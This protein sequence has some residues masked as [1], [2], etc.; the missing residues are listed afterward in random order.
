[1][2]LS[3]LGEHRPPVWQ[4]QRPALYPIPES[5]VL[6][7]AALVLAPG[8]PRY[9]CSVEVWGLSRASSILLDSIPTIHWV[10]AGRRRHVA[11]LAC[12]FLQLKT[13]NTELDQAK[14]E[15]RSAQKDLQN[16]DK[17]ITVRHPSLMRSEGA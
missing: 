15:L 13:V 12:P 4:L 5:R 7:P 6:G 8:S 14:L 2:H 10:A 16:A 11:P 9:I 17:E 3:W 1:M